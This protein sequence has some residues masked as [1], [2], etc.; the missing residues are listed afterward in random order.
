M[1]LN[2]YYNNQRRLNLYLKTKFKKIKKEC[3]QEAI[4]MDFKSLLNKRLK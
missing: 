2:P 1:I 3:I 4:A